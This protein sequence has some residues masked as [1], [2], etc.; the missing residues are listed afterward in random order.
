[1]ARTYAGILGPLALVT[2][3]ARGFLNGECVESIVFTAWLGLLAFAAVGYVIGRIAEWIVDES[4]GA[5]VAAELAAEK[6]KAKG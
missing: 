6:S 1:M 4:V 3:L 2:C 5:A